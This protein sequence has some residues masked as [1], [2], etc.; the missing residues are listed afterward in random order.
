MRAKY[1][2]C[3][4][5]QIPLWSAAAPAYNVPVDVNTAPFDMARICAGIGMGVVA[6]NRSSF[7]DPPTRSVS[8][9]ELLA[10]SD[11]VSLHLGLNEETKGFLGRE[12]VAAMKR[13]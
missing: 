6:W 13:L 1:F 11:I 2:D 8:L 9:D 5:G 4:A 3:G 10:T 7:S 12:R